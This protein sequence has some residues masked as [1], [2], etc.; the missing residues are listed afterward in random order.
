MSRVGDRGPSVPVR[1][2]SADRV[3]A[4]GSKEPQFQTG[5]HDSKGRSVSFFDTVKSFA[6]GGAGLAAAPGLVL[7]DSSEK[8]GRQAADEDNW[9]PLTALW[10]GGKFLLGSGL[11]VGGALAGGLLGGIIGV[12]AGIGRW[13]FG[14]TK[15]NRSDAVAKTADNYGTAGQGLASRQRQST[16]DGLRDSFSV[17]EPVRA[18]TVKTLTPDESRELK[19]AGVQSIFIESVSVASSDAGSASAL[20][21]KQVNF[22]KSAAVAAGD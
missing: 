12:G 8:S 16:D 6:K 22:E 2:V 13:L 11:A 19:N 15:E 18:R 14:S 10:N 5:G 9:N 21:Q 1:T 17:S 4:Q 7:V 3:Q 20:A